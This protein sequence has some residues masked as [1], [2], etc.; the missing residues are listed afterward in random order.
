MNAWW[1]ALIGAVLILG[2]L[3]ALFVFAPLSD[4]ERERLRIDDEVGP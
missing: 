1:W 2:G 4:A 3:I